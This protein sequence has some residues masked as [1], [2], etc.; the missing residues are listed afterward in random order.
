MSKFS[1]DPRKLQNEVEEL[2]AQ[3]GSLRRTVGP[4]T[5]C[6]DKFK[7]LPQLDGLNATADRIAKL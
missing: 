2:R 3:I 6:G 7:I 4:L 5:A 1:I